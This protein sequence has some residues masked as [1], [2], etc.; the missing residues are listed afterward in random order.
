MIVVAVLSGVFFWAARYTLREK[1]PFPDYRGIKSPTTGLSFSSSPAQNGLSGVP[2]A[3]M[4]GMRRVVTM[5]TTYT[6]RTYSQPSAR[7][8]TASPITLSV[9]VQGGGLRLSSGSTVRSYGSGTGVSSASSTSTGRST[10]RS[11]AGG[12][13]GLVSTVGGFGNTSITQSTL[14]AQAASTETMVRPTRQLT[15]LTESNYSSVVKRKGYGTGDNE[16]GNP[17]EDL[18]LP[19]SGEYDGQHKKGND[20]NWY[21]WYLGGWHKEASEAGEDGAPI[22][23]GLALLL[24]MAA[25]W[26]VKKKKH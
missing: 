3:R 15:L 5:T 14:I 6:S 2:S 17:Y 13:H 26:A 10:S 4:Q 16:E 1:D 11:T 21:T 18:G 7:T 8:Y 24:L 22:G 19:E 23:N 9:P 25:G 20:G 12:G